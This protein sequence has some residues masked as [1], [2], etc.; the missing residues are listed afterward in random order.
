VAYQWVD[1]DRNVIVRRY[2]H[3]AGLIPFI[4]RLLFL[5]PGLRKSAA[6]RLELKPG[7]R[8]LEIG[9][10]TGINFSYLQ[11][12]VG[13]SGHIYGVDI[14]PGMLLKARE[15]CAK[16]QWNNVDLVKCDAADYVAPEPLDGVLFSLSYNT[17]P[18]HL[19]VLRRAWEQ[20]RPGG[21]LVIMDAKL[22]PGLMGKLILPF[23][24][25]LMKRTMLGN[26]L[27]RPWEELADLAD[28]F[29]MD[30]FLFS[31]YY[32][33]RGIKAAASTQPFDQTDDRRVRDKRQTVRAA[34]R[35]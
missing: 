10:G 19:A 30:E 3:I 13:P 17:M 12:A 32:V 29:E 27:I 22:P 14:S 21:R 8:V 1:C 18:H 28:R 26:P 6:E 16:H 34:A 9:C 25:W 35:D 7:D 33:C 15:Q 2:D 20:L 4:D 24:L 11:N 5:P 23:S 31:S